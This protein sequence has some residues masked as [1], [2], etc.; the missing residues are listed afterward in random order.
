MLVASAFDYAKS[1]RVITKT[2]HKT[3]LASF[4]QA[5]ENIYE[6]FDRVLVLDKGRCIYFGRAKDA[7]GYFEDLGFQ[8]EDRKSTPDFLTG[9]TN[10]QERKIRPG[11]EGVPINSVNLAAAYKSSSHYELAMQELKEYEQEL[12]AEVITA[13][14]VY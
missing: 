2:L 3:T 9:I 13:P 4:Y 7:K 6:Q 11:V 10:P 1:L 12:A 14:Y 8:C 5:S